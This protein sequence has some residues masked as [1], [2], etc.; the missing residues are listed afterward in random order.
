MGLTDRKD[1]GHGKTTDFCRT[2]G[3]YPGDSADAICPI[4][5]GGLAGITPQR[6][7]PRH[8]PV[9]GPGGGAGQQRSGGA[10][11]RAVCGKRPAICTLGGSGGA[12]GRHDTDCGQ[13]HHT[14]DR[15]WPLHSICRGN[16]GDGSRWERLC[17]RPR[18]EAVFYQ[19]WKL[20]GH[21]GHDAPVA[22]RHSLCANGLCAAAASVAGV[23]QPL[24]ALS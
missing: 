6:E 3:R 11:S 5:C 24:C 15:G 1:G 9:A 19:A 20:P 13:Y 7:C 12:V 8:Y 18:A 22:G 4:G 23:S 17:D 14:P 16:A 10:G 21:R 2:A